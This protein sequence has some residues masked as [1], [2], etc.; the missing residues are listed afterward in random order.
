MFT[1][2]TTI[3]VIT[4]DLL[5]LLESN[6][7]ILCNLITIICGTCI[8]TTGVVVDGEVD[9]TVEYLSLLYLPFYILIYMFWDMM[10]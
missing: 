1:N 4:I 9:F 3:F 6:L 5:H 10:L 8:H 7:T 2:T